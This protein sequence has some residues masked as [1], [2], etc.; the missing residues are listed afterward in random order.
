MNMN[1]NMLAHFNNPP[2][3]LNPR[4]S[5]LTPL[6]KPGIGNKLESCG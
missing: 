1:M 4:L 3:N 2:K 5:P 6:R